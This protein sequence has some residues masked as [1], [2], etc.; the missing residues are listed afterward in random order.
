MLPLLFVVVTSS[1]S[2]VGK[3]GT[4]VVESQ[5]KQ[6]KDDVVAPVDVA[7]ATRVLEPDRAPRLE[8]DQS[9][10][11]MLSTESPSATS[12]KKIIDGISNV[13][14]AHLFYRSQLTADVEINFEGFKQSAPFR[15][16]GDVANG[17]DLRATIEMLDGRGEQHRFSVVI[18]DDMTYRKGEN[19]QVWME[20]SE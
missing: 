16:S 5:E 14:D 2:A 13:L 11:G 4:V 10:A 1:C 8:R 19:D 18:I 6:N 20:Y 7:T 3:S 15:M 12:S 9:P 17:S